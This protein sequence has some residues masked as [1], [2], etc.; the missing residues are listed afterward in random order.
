MHTCLLGVY[1]RVEAAHCD[2]I[3]GTQLGAIHGSK[4]VRCNVWEWITRGVKARNLS[5]LLIIGK[6]ELLNH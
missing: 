4:L 6:R 3:V 2:W 5:E 1:V